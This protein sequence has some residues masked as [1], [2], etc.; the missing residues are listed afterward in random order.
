MAQPCPP[1]RWLILV[2][3]QV[4]PLKSLLQKLG[5]VGC[6]SGEG[7]L[8]RPQQL[9][10]IDGEVYRREPKDVEAFCIKRDV[11][12]PDAS[13]GLFQLP[14]EVV[15]RD[16]VS[17]PQLYG[18][19]RDHKAIAVV[20]DTDAVGPI[21]ILFTK[22]TYRR[23]PHAGHRHPHHETE[24]LVIVVEGSMGHKHHS[25]NAGVVGH[26]CDVGGVVLSQL[27]AEDVLC[28]W[29][30]LGLLRG[31]FRIIDSC[32][33]LCLV[34]EWLNAVSHFFGCPCQPISQ[35]LAGRGVALIARREQILKEA[36]ILHAALEKES[37]TEG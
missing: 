3:F 7:N 23:I 26:R 20:V 13:R 30:R 33:L 24:I 16:M 27:V 22:H 12:V 29:R 34:D 4:G 35:P 5:L 8:I 14:D 2:N 1:C 9:R 18:D 32:P 17:L 19:F 28:L 11:F 6:V 37:W 25:G 36:C 21:E 15:T 31:E 10:R